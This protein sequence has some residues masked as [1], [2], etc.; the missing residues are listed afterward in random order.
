MLDM[1]DRGNHYFL[2]TAFPPISLGAKPDLSFKEVK[3]MLQLNLSAADWKK[4]RLLLRPLDLLNIRALWLG[5][6]LDDRGNLKAK[7]LEE[8]LLV[9]AGLPSY[10]IDYLER[11]ETTG[12]R[13][14]NFS[15]LFASLYREELPKLKGFL[16]KYYQLE[17]EIRLILTALR[18]KQMGRDLAKELQFED[19][20]DPLVAELLA[21]KDAADI[22]PPHGFED[23]KNLFMDHRSDPQT[24]HRAM[25]EYRLERIEE[26]EEVQDFGI[27]RVLAYLAR[28][29]L[30]ESYAELNFEKGKEHLGQYE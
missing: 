7:D 20:T 14:H 12:D 25:L 29:L 13:L 22:I 15:S 11:Y 23:L 19:P 21:Q 9:E 27:D 6:P 1:L 5:L 28:L 30:V 18:A 24:L 2:I 26:M 16:L 17:R 4:V 3:E 8:H 10:V